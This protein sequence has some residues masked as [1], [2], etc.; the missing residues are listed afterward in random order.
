M[1]S[2]GSA[3][4]RAGV[5]VAVA[6]TVMNLGTYGYTMV[7]ARLLGPRTYGEFT[8]LMSTLL[9]LG[10]AQ[11]GLQA[12][13]AR[14]LAADP[15]H[16]A[17][18]RRSTRAVTLTAATLI[19]IGSLLAAPLLASA[20]HL[21]SLL[22]AALVAPAA[23]AMTLMGGQAGILQGERRWN[24]LAVVYLSNGLPRLAIG[25]ALL[26]WQTNATTAML[27]VCL[28]QFVPVVVGAVA[29]GER[30]AMRPQAG[31]PGRR[32]VAVESLHASATLLTFFV[33][34]S[35][36]I[37]IAR[38]RLDAHDAGLYAA[39][40]I[41][42]KAV[43]FLPQFV[44]VVAFPTMS[45]PEQHRRAVQLSLALVAGLGLACVAGTL[46]LPGLAMIV[47][48]GPA[49]EAIRGSLWQFALL[50]TTLSV[51]QLLVYSVL[52]QRSRR[53]SV[54]VGIG[55]IA[56]VAAGSTATDWSELLHRVLL[57]DAVLAAVLLALGLSGRPRAS[58]APSPR[59]RPAAR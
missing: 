26:L 44:M 33:L 18:V 54:V 3:R 38:N 43:L 8:A 5:A 27:A 4:S 37:L 41:V 56:L 17:A 20:L 55:I 47:A 50:G 10:V 35:I 30:P 25:T 46:V 1:S 28:S 21:H 39:G 45:R 52:A 34:S 59:R 40:L 6:M 36:D 11:L 48:G 19:G 29:L 58:S 22:A 23:F 13:A 16:L 57:V 53:A 42:V 24:A 32:E 31:A 49:Y 12:T 14:R 7:A 9:V 51:L 15:E 2:S